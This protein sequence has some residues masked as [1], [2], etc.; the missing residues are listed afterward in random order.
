MENASKALL[1]AG[2]ILIAMVTVSLFYFMFNRVGQFQSITQTNYSQEELKDFNKGFEA[3]NKKLMYG[4]D[5]ISVI[6]KAVD[7]N[8]RNE[9]FYYDK[10]K[11]KWISDTNNDYY[12]D[13]IVELKNPL[14]EGSLEEF[15][16]SKNYED[17]Y[18][19]I[20]NEYISDD[21]TKTS[22]TFKRKNFSCTNVEYYNGANQSG[23]VKSMTFTER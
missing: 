7:N 1:M 14:F 23:R 22:S 5:V 13:I 15:T 18:K 12:V 3:Y 17:I 16:I 11:D 8:Q 20:V 2:G 10:K 21:G 6:N 19:Y 9:V 4:S